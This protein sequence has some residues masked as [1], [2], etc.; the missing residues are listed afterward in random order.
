MRTLKTLTQTAALLALTATAQVA[1]ATCY[2]VY[3]P[4]SSVVFRSLKS[5][6][7]LSLPLHMTLPVVAPG[8]R[9]VF[10]PDGYGCE[11]ETNNLDTLHNMSPKA[12]TVRKRSTQQRRKAR[13]AKAA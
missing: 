13:R 10:A 3:A 2:M 9:L 7:D 5:P 1:N 8:G 4:D 12:S 11:F 6:V